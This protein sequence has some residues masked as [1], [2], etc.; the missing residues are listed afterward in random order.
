MRRP[1]GTIGEGGRALRPAAV[2]LALAV[3]LA[4][5]WWGP[6]TPAAESSATPRGIDVARWQHP[7]GKAIDWQAVRGAGIE[8]A[9]VK[10]TEST[11]YVNP[12][13]RQ[14]TD[15]VRAVGLVRGAY[16]FA[17]PSRPVVDDARAEARHFARVIARDLGPGSLP[18]A[19]DLE[20]SGGLSRTELVTWTRTF[21]D[22]LEAQT[23]RLP[24]IYTYKS[25]WRVNM[26]DSRAFHRYPLWL[27]YY[28]SSLGGLVGDWP[29]HAIWQYS[30]GGRVPGISGNVDM[31]LFN[32]SRAQLHALAAGGPAEMAPQAPAAPLRM[33]TEPGDGRVVVTWEP[34]WDGGAPITSYNIRVRPS[35]RLITVPGDVRRVVVDGLDNATSYRF[36]VTAVNALGEGPEVAQ[37]R[38]PSAPTAAVLTASTSTLVHGQRVT[39]T[40][41]LFDPR[42]KAPLARRTVAV[43]GRVRGASAF[44][45]VDT[46]R[47]SAAGTVRLTRTPGANV[48]YRLRYAGSLVEAPATAR[49]AVDV[50]ARMTGRFTKGGSPV[51]SVPV[52]AKLRLSGRVSPAHAGDVVLRQQW[53]GNRWVTLARAR[54]SP[55]GT[56]GFGLQPVSRGTKTF[57]VFLPGTRTHVASA[58]G[59]LRLV[60][61]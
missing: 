54:V 59:R 36:A 1:T 60:V 50:K 31:N 22:T 4:S 52:R 58:T 34:G 48:E 57:R 40:G 55:Q 18:P 24:M 35:G 39:L 7:F 37:R 43:E 42:T 29:R 47:T 51:A 38:S 19:L 9:I 49:R 5:A 28:N 61:R 53:A 41:R 17:R 2:L 3:L 10:A 56:Y 15:G 26:G 30:A 23:G 8:F 6:S 11:T 46:L 20:Q 12:Y 27:A 21:L 13:Y 45:R 44:T 33:T 25:F 32:G 16:H 14:D